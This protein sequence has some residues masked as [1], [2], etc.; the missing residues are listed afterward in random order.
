MLCKGFYSLVVGIINSL[1]RSSRSFC[2]TN[3]LCLKSRTLHFPFNNLCILYMVYMVYTQCCIVYSSWGRGDLGDK[4][5]GMLVGSFQ[6]SKP[7]K[8]YQTFF[9]RAW[10]HTFFITKRKFTLCDSSKFRIGQ[11]QN[12]TG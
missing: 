2:D 4:R 10:L 7:P 6:K 11:K 12:I 3:N 5:S 8:I 1:A 9:K